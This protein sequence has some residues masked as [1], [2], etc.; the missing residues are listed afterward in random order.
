[1]TPN[2][3]YE[4]LIATMSNVITDALNDKTTGLIEFRLLCENAWDLVNGWRKDH[5]EN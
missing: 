5:D 1:M 2:F 3:E 4:E